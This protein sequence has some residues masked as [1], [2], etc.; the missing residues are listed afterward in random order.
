ML[1]MLRMALHRGVAHV[2]RTRIPSAS[3]V[4]LGITLTKRPAAA[5]LA[6]L[7]LTCNQTY[8][9]GMKLVHNVGLEQKAMM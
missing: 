1:L 8:L 5:S 6:H 2:P 7:T 9:L 4:P 3:L